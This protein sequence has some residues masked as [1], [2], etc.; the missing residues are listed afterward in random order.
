[1]PTAIE[2]ANQFQASLVGDGSVSLDSLAPLERATAQQISFLSNPLYRQ[3]AIHSA[4]G[5]LIVGQSDLDFLQ[6]NSA[7]SR[8]SRVYFLARNPYATFARMA[9]YFAAQKPNQ[10]H[11]GVHP[12]AA[13]D[14]SA[15]VP[16]SCHIGPFVHIAKG[17]VLGE[18]VSIMANTTVAAGVR[19]GDDS[20][21]YPSVSIY[22]DC[23]IGQRCIIHSGA[24][25]GA[26]GFGFAPDFNASGAEWVKIPQ[27]GAVLIGDDVEI[28]ASTTIDRGAMSNTVIGSGCKIDNQVQIGHNAVI[29]TCTVIAGCAG[30]SGSTT[31]GNYC[32]IGGYASFA[33]HLTIA[34]RT[35]VSGGTSII[36]SI[37]EPG[38]H[39]TGVYPSMPH[40]AW[41]KNSAIARGL[42]KIRQRLRHLE[43][44]KT[45]LD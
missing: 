24:V 10:R 2:L 23:D 21:I 43:N 26:D 32:V 22:A 4:A 25:I 17:V 39:F 42:D 14:P 9:Q 11:P 44:T 45:K 31:I 37:T 36:R 6:A 27:T 28:G 18:R 13:I 33:G 41:E 1:M 15:S 29:G 3:Q 16:A 30:I 20:L 19:I 8:V 5:A 35:T 40:A 38:Q 7:G 34:D 12:Q